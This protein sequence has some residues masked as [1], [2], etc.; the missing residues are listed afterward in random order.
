MDGNVNIIDE[1]G[2]IEGLNSVQQ[3]ATHILTPTA[4]FQYRNFI[5][6]FYHI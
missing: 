2:T 1:L 5:M 4:S 3:P 6:G